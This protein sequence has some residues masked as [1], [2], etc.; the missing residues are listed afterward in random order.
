MTNET[1][2]S[3]AIAT[4][5]SNEMTDQGLAELRERFPAD[6]VHDM[7]NE[8]QFKAARKTR[9]ER[10]K[11]V[12]SIKS[13]R[14]GVTSEIKIKAED[15]TNEVE[16]I[17]SSVVGPFETQLEV[18]KIAKEK[19]ERELKELIDSQ[20][21][22]INNMNNFVNECI[23]KTS[24]SISDVIEAVD[25][26]ETTVFHKDIIHEA[27]EVKKAV[28]SSLAELLAQALNE[29]SLALERAK[30]VEQQEEADKAQLIA[31]LKV[32]TQ[33]RLNK[34]MMIPTS[35]YGKTSGEIKAKIDS[36][37]NYEVPESEFGESYQQAVDSVKTVIS[38]LTSMFDQQIIIEEQVRLIESQNQ[39]SELDKVVDNAATHG[40]GIMDSKGKSIPFEEFYQQPVFQE[41]EVKTSLNTYDE[42]EHMEYFFG[43][44]AINGLATDSSENKYEL[45]VIVRRVALKI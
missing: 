26:I 21:I 45:E 2:I 28:Q 18:N 19:A 5:F 24:K 10:N 6:L 30:L 32:K 44:E 14:L 20:R 41:K 38:Q 27:I 3:T 1:P 8:T 7:T 36:L 35:L 12:E 39:E 13:R 4:L 37:N 42:R 9:T 15:L 11:L 40:T 29:E 23:G 31:D 43:N 34:L 25:L 17:Y 16:L 33:E 22:D